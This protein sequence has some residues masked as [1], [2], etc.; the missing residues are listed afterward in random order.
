MFK[1]I[2]MWKLKKEISV[3]DGG[4]RIVISNAQKKI[5]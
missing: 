3:V 2:V 5:L 1:H 4:V